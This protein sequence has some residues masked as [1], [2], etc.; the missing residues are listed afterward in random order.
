MVDAK[1]KTGAARVEDL[2][3]MLAYCT[4]LGLT[5]G[6]LIY[7]ADGGDA[8]SKSATVRRAGVQIT[9]A[10]LDVSVS[11][12]LMLSQLRQLEAGLHAARV[13][14]DAGVRR[15]PIVGGTGSH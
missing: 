5:E 4:V 15:S 11:P 3:Q 1:Y 10:R 7:V 13:A 9:T 8:R 2:Y 6:T 12:E 14:G